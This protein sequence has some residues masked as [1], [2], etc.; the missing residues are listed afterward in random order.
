VTERRAAIEIHGAVQGVGFRP[1]VYRLAAEMELFG[2]VL[3]DV[4]GVFIEVDGA[5][6]DLIHFISRLE[7]ELPPVAAVDT[8]DVT[9]HEP[10]GFEGFEIRHSDGTG[11]RT[12]VILPDL[13]VCRECAAEVFDASDRRAGYPFTNCT[14]C[15]PRF[16]IIEE[17]PYDRP[18]TTMSSFT[19]CDECASEYLDPNDRRFHAQPNACPV[20]GPSLIW[21]SRGTTDNT[22]IAAAVAM[23][24]AGGIVALK[25]IGGYQL[26]VDA[27]N[28][29]A[30]ARLRDAKDRPDKPFAVMVFD[31]ETAARL[32]EFSD[33]AAILLSSPQSPIVLLPARGGSLLSPAIAPGNPTVGVMLPTTP[34]HQLLL[35]RL[36]GPVVATSGNLTDEPIAIDNHEAVH[37]LGNIAD[38]FL[39]HNRPIQRHVDDSV[40]WILEDTPRLLRRARGYAPM[41]VTTEHPLPPI[42]ATGAHLKNT[43][44]VSVGRNVFVSQHIGD[45]ETEEAHRAFTQVIEDLTRMYDVK[46]AALAH[47]LHPDYVS[48]RFAL[49]SGVH[50]DVPKIAVQ[51]HHAHL[52]SC[53]ADNG[54][55][56]SALGVTWDGTGYGTDGTIWGGEFLLGDA[57]GFERV[58]HLRAFRLP[59]SEVAVREPRRCA[60]GIL[61]ELGHDL[62]RDLPGLS[63]FSDGELAVI[64]T[65][66]ER[67]INTPMT[68]SAGRLFDAVAAL[69]GIADVTSFEGQAAMALEHVADASV[70]DAYP[71]PMLVEGKAV[72][73]DWGEMV[74]QILVDL[75]HNED[76][77]QMAGRFHA[78]LV[79][80]VVAVARAI[81][82]PTVA[83]SGGCFQNRILT[84]HAAKALRDEG[85]EVL[86]HRR[87]PP[88]D[89]GISL[90]QIMIAA[91]SLETPDTTGEGTVQA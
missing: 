23:V 65:M 88:N 56:G 78:A 9:W 46:P 60:A 77:A 53:L 39:A 19:M 70:R 20:C 64:S 30:V 75:A 80:G 45:L 57:K 82:H 16:S 72:V 17:L 10:A 89:G 52:V 34:L 73:L 84:E 11:A 54:E 49:E 31:L 79:Q 68:T 91:A 44:A 48:T 7:A 66:L 6:N 5:E 87:V 47:D 22:A 71:L 21:T 2:W 35:A 12:A 42:L 1:F 62:T 4:H 26:L 50:A 24:E 83:L 55:S 41:P 29:Q 38:G 15:G 74:S 61:W 76:I 8:M 43:I 32:V 40:A 36:G 37:R 90:G 14:N 27:T 28:D 51:H 58:G 63:T 33:E 25:G 86:L 3:N 67:G 85:F 18:N 59:G 13:V 69:I 81:D